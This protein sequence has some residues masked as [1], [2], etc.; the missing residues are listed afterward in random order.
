M[1]SD[2]QRDG[3]RTDVRH[4]DV[5]G[6]NGDGMVACNPRDREAAHRADV[7]DITTTTDLAAVTCRKCISALRREP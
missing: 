7:G 3:N 5:H 2:P 4:R 6:L 1:S